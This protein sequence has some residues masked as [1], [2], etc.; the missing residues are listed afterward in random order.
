M[1]T[2]A[3]SDWMIER[4]FKSL[5]QLRNSSERE[6]IINYLAF[7][8]STLLN[9]GCCRVLDAIFEIYFLLYDCIWIYLVLKSFNKWLTS[10]MKNVSIPS[11]PEDVDIVVTHKSLTDRAIAVRPNAIHYSVEN[12]LEGEQYDAIIEKIKETR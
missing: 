8:V 12:F 4:S 10:E 7:F 5:V 11:L 6:R 1:N 2:S 3:L 9:Y